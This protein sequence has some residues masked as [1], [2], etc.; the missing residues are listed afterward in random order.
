MDSYT[1]EEM[2]VRSDEVRRAIG[3]GRIALTRMFNRNKLIIGLL[4]IAL[5]FLTIAT[6][7]DSVRQGTDLDSIRAYASDRASDLADLRGRQYGTEVDIAILADRFQALDD[8]VW[9]M[10][11]AV[12][13]LQ[14]T[15]YSGST[16]ATETPTP[17]PIN[18]FVEAKADISLCYYDS[19]WEYLEYGDAVQY[20]HPDEVCASFYFKGNDSLRYEKV[21]LTPPQYRALKD[22]LAKYENWADA[23]FTVGAIVQDGE[24]KDIRWVKGP[25]DKEVWNPSMQAGPR[26]LNKLETW[27]ARYAEIMDYGFVAEEWFDE[28]PECASEPTDCWTGHPCRYTEWSPA[29]VFARAQA[30]SEFVLNPENNSWVEIWGAVDARYRWIDVISGDVLPMTDRNAGLYQLP[31]SGWLGLQIASDWSDETPKWTTTYNI[32]VQPGFVVG[33]DQAGYI[34]E[35]GPLGWVRGFEDEWLANRT[36][37]W[38]QDKLSEWLPKEGEIEELRDYYD[39]TYK[40]ETPTPTAT[41]AVTK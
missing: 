5:A 21:T 8:V 27:S 31:K 2:E 24:V 16:D 11:Y 10:E 9:N 15:V 32:R 41:P 33:I 20:Y 23:E 35:S 4:T 34:F 12:E 30:F 1:V 38:S 7:V 28:M 18:K 25:L 37:E 13:D 19:V 3:S 39:N 40:V 6:A 14:D 36:S 26:F 29:E 22:A 17:A